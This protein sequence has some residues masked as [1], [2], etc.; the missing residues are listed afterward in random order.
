[1]R[2]NATELSVRAEAAE[3]LR[4]RRAILADKDSRDDACYRKASKVRQKQW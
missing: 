1:M 3:A 2:V 4:Q